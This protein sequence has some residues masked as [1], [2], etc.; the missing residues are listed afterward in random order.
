LSTRS[1]SS[2]HSIPNHS[3]KAQAKVA[4]EC[5]NAKSV[6]SKVRSKWPH[7][8]MLSSSKWSLK[9]KPNAST[10]PHSRTKHHKKLNSMHQSKSIMK[11]M[12]IHNDKPLRWTSTGSG[13]RSM[14]YS[15]PGDSPPMSSKKVKALV[16]ETSKARLAKLA[17]V[18]IRDCLVC[19]I[20]F[21]RT[22]TAYVMNIRGSM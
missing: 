3:E 22:F 11:I 15:S 1:S 8:A 10:K 6:S 20:H 13:R 7:G 19:S 14:R 18:I 12:G 16:K 9:D 4:K 5:P 2:E 21:F 17:Q